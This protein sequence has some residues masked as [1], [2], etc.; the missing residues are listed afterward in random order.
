[1]RRSLQL[2]VRRGHLVAYAVLVATTVALAMALAGPSVFA[3][4]PR[5]VKSKKD[6][7]AKSLKAQRDA[8]SGAM[9]AQAE[10]QMAPG[11]AAVR[12]RQTAIRPV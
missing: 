1:M 7:P 3:D 5:P 4:T 12:P 11:L 6:R 10:V 2:L 8:L 9:L